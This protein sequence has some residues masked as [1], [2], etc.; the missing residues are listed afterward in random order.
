VLSQN[1]RLGATFRQPLE[2]ISARFV[3][4]GAQIDF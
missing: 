3:K 4:I 2:I 1:G